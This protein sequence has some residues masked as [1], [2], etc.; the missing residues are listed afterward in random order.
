MVVIYILPIPFHVVP[1]ITVVFNVG[2]SGGMQV[3]CQG[4]LSQSL[5]EQRKNPPSNLNGGWRHKNCMWKIAVSGK[6]GAHVPPTA[7]LFRS[8]AYW[9]RSCVAHLQTFIKLVN[10]NHMMPTRYTLDMDLKN[11]VT[12]DAVDPNNPTKKT[13]ARKVSRQ[14][15]ENCQIS[16][17]LQHLWSS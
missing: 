6:D 10:Y 14:T 5:T 7:F 12:Q 17:V 4:F 2:F 9:A 16:E 8:L 15:V 13:E 3:T 1:F 11:V